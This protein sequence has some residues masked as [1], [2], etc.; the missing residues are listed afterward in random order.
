[1]N[2]AL[3]GEIPEWFYTRNIKRIL[4][5]D[6]LRGR[7]RQA[8]P[9]LPPR[10][11]AWARE[12][13][14]NLAAGLRDSKYHI[15]GDLT[16]LLSEPA[17]GRY[18][19]PADLPA[20]PLLDAAVSAAVA[21]ADHTYR[22]KCPPRR[23][24]QSPPGLR[25][26]ASKLEWAVLNGS[27]TRRLLRNTSHLAAV[28]RLRVAI[29]LVLMHPSRHRPAPSPPAGPGTGA[30]GQRSPAA[31]AASAPGYGRDEPASH[32]RHQSRTGR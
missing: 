8:R 17:P 27:W 22:E 6:V 25:Q 24:R 19:A 2:K 11:E 13:S 31:R 5:H 3:P 7:A 18:V 12:Q 20:Q 26:K 16:D 28:R 30:A 21:L 9:A 15:V 32:Q 14:E 4:A 10:L 23:P 1:M 29:W